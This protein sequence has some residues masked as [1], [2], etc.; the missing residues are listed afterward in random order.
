MIQLEKNRLKKK[1]MASCIPQVTEAGW[2][3]LHICAMGA[4]NDVACAQLLLEA[5][6]SPLVRDLNQ[7]TAYDVAVLSNNEPLAALLRRPRPSFDTRRRAMRTYRNRCL[8][9]DKPKRPPPPYYATI[10]GEPPLP[11]VI[12]D[13]DDEAEETEAVLDEDAIKQMTGKDLRAALT[14]RELSTRG[15]KAALRV[16]LLDA[17]NREASQ[18]LL[19]LEAE[20]VE[21]EEVDLSGKEHAREWLQLQT[22]LA[23]QRMD[24]WDGTGPRPVQLAEPPKELLIPEHLQLPYAKENFTIGTARKDKSRRKRGP[25]IIHNLIFNRKSLKIH[26]KCGRGRGRGR[27]QGG[28]EQTEVDARPQERHRGHVAPRGVGRGRRRDGGL[29]HIKYM[30]LH[31]VP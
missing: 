12:I 10:A 15:M 3:H 5:G 4:L 11:E 25:H 1:P 2:T 21:E 9:Q 29:R 22:F 6:V 8:L 28:A 26:K 30:C 18:A 23:D 31:T 19:A 14:E 27:G 16:R 17:V 24:N 20:E 7:R 13:T